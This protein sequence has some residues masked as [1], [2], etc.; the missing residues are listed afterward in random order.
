[1]YGTLFIPFSGAP[2]TGD[3]KFHFVFAR[4]ALIKD[5][6]GYCVTA[7][8]GAD[9]LTID[10]EKWNGSDWTESIFS[11]PKNLITG[12]NIAGAV[13]PDGDYANRCFTGVSGTT[14]TDGT[15]RLNLD[16]VG[17][18]IADIRVMIRCLQYRN[19]LEDFLAVDDI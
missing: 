6:Q 14:V 8:G 16:T 2:E 9:N 5:V 13:Q 11:A 3:G 12:A 10:I 15:L 18:N 17:G 7:P 1:V 19:P 4:P